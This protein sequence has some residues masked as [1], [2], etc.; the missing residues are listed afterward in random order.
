MLYKGEE[1]IK[2]GETE[3]AILN[4]Y[5]SNKYARQ[6]NEESDIEIS[7]DRLRVKIITPIFFKIGNR[8]IA[9]MISILNFK[10]YKKK[11]KKQ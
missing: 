1:R 5:N 4:I 8:F 10:K 6:L 11:V 3:F 2:I 9:T 7:E